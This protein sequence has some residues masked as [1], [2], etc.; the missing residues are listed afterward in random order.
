[1]SKTEAAL[2]QSTRW[3]SPGKPTHS[4]ITGNSRTRSLIRDLSRVLGTQMRYWGMDARGGADSLLVSAGLERLARAVS[5]GEGS[6]RYRQPWEGGWIEIHSF[7]AGFY[8][9]TN[10][11]VLF[12]RA[13]RRIFCST[14]GDI[15][16]PLLHREHD[17]AA[18]PDRILVSLPPFLRWLLD[19]ESRVD[20][21]AGTGYR[22][23]CWKSLGSHRLG[24]PPVEMRDWIRSF[25]LQPA[26]TGRLQQIMKSSSSKTRGQGGLTR[27]ARG[28]QT[29]HKPHFVRRNPENGM[30]PLTQS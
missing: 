14:V 5:I 11:G 10:P 20:A 18:P 22:M 13:E 15:A 24:P 8:H 12:S 19:Y 9:P 30:P 7:C 26:K 16:E 29:L 17:A 3:V 23:R 1:M 6:S 28:R 2:H 21:V 25:L 27:Y 4:E